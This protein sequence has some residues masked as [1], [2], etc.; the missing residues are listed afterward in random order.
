MS[1]TK[2]EATIRDASNAERRGKSA[3]QRLRDLR[4]ERLA[5]GIANASMN[6]SE[7]SRDYL[8][9]S[10]NGEGTYRLL[11]TFAHGKPWSLFAS[12]VTVL[13]GMIPPPQGQIGEVT[14]RDDVS[15]AMTQIA[16][17]TYEAA[18]NDLEQFFSHP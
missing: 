3:V 10:S 4:H 12:E 8:V 14:A 16:V 13:L 17:R 7:A 9:G 5:N 1:G 18:V 15:V 2:F 11:S 6:A